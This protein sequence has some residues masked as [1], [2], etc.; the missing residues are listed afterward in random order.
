MKRL[1]TTNGIYVAQVEALYQ[2]IPMVLLVNLV[3]SALVAIVLA[4]YMGQTWWL[5]FLAL[6]FAL[7]AARAIRVGALSPQ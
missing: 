1:G 6:T 2:H 7:S 4:S 5:V 3:N